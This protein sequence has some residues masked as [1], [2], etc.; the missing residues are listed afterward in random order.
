MDESNRGSG[1]IQISKDE[2]MSAHVE[3]LLKR[4]MSLRGETGITREIGRR[5]YYQ[6]WFVFMLVGTVAA[7]A[8]WGILEPYFSD[9]P[10]IQGN[11]EKIE[12]DAE[13]SREPLISSQQI[14][15]RSKST[16]QITV[17]GERRE[18]AGGATLAA[19]LE[20]LKLSAGGL[21]CELNGEIVRRADYGR[22]P[23]KEG[24]VLEIVQMVGG[25]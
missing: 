13:L 10:Y 14:R 11:I 19:Y 15:V 12:T 9:I 17:N 18:T 21:A 22:T 4:Q 23:L 2:A 3:D 20:S 25:G 1:V 16:C 8:A 24:D 6:N 5:W 7:I